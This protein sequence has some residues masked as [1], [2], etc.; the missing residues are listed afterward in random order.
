MSKEKLVLLDIEVYI[1]GN[2]FNTKEHRK[3]TASNSYIKFGSSHPSHCFKGIIKSQMYRLRRLC[4]KDSDFISAVDVL[5]KRC[6]MSGYDKDMVENII[7]QAA[8]L[9]RSLKRR[10]Q[11]S[12]NTTDEM[13]T[14]RWVVLSGTSYEKEISNFTRNINE[15]LKNHKIKLE[16]VKS[17]GS[18]IGRLLFNN[19]EKF[20]APECN[21]GNCY[22]CTNE[23]KDPGSQVTSKITHYDYQLD[24]KLNCKDSGIYRIT[25]PC[26][27]A[28]TGKTTTS[29]SQRFDEHF[30]QYHKS[31][32]NDHSKECPQGR[33]KEDYR[34]HFLENVH[35]RGKYTLSEREFLWNERLGGEINIQKI[36]RNN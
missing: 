10:N 6:I 34:V 4:S 28:Y 26:S 12:D 29:F 32:V 17:T 23:I 11:P 33:I 31:S 21:V 9:R 5:K 7:S 2:Q 14:I 3:E 18:N 24:K 30:K 25:C 36:L 27:A 35:S 16:I 20:N 8:T 1:D 22:I 15:L 19:R 13:K